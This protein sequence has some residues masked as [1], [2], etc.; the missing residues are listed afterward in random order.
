M[1]DFGDLPGRHPRPADYAEILTGDR[2]KL[3]ALR[4][5]IVIFAITDGWGTRTHYADDTLSYL[6]LGY[7]FLRGH[8]S[9]AV[10]AYW[11]PLYPALLTLPLALAKGQPIAEFVWVKILNIALFAVDLLAFEFLIAELW[12]CTAETG[13]DS[14]G[15]ANFYMVSYVVFLW[16]SFRMNNVSRMTPDQLCMA[17][18][19]ASSALLLRLARGRQ[20]RIVYGLL[21]FSL[22]IGYLAKTVMLPLGFVLAAAAIVVSAKQN[23]ARILLTG[24]ALLLTAG[25]LIAVLTAKTGSLTIGEA[26]K[27]N[28]AWCVTKI[29]G[30]YLHW[31]G[32]GKTGQPLHATR[33]LMSQPSVYEFAGPVRTHYSPWTDPSYWY[34]GLRPQFSIRQQLQAL[35]RN[36]HSLGGYAIRDPFLIALAV[37][38]LWFA[39]FRRSAGAVFQALK[40]FWWLWL[41]PVSGTLLYLCVF[42][43]M[44]YLAGFGAILAL[45]FIVAMLEKNPGAANVIIPVLFL[46]ALVSAV[47]L[48]YP[49]A[50]RIAEYGGAVFDDQWAAARE[51]K[52]LGLLPGDPVG[53]IGDSVQA[54]W[55]H[56]ADLR[57]VTEIPLRVNGEPGGEVDRFRSSGDERRREVFAAMKMTG[58]RAVIADRSL[59]SPPAGEWVRLAGTSYYLHW[60]EDD[61]R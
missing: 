38:S 25:P 44:R 3:F 13:R 10:S 8:W 5:T 20:E 33:L 50:S 6:D 28:Y 32:G 57:I 61:G 11:S 34:A 9:N 16:T 52:R 40:P 29:Q 19:F 39:F 27:L 7:E 31:Q 23:R 15:R 51:L 58:A 37:C 12:R 59:T 26:G 53:S 17:A 30:S 43:E 1:P 42:V 18:L 48:I 22:G 21:G 55:A 35:Y 36:A 41:T 56:L 4:L 60:L 2:R 54:T 14:V 46:G 47:P 49:A 45:I 24:A